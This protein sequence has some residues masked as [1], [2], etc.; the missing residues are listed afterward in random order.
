MIDGCHNFN[1][2]TPILFLLP[3]PSTTIKQERGGNTIIVTIMLLIIVYG[4]DY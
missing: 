2:H 3:K 4:H 1:N